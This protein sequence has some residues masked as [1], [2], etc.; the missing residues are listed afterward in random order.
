MN[1]I[2]IIIITSYL[3]GITS[4]INA[5]KSYKTYGSSSVV[6]TRAVSDNYAA[7]YHWRWAYWTDLWRAANSWKSQR[8]IKEDDWWSL[9]CIAHVLMYICICHLLVFVNPVL[10]LVLMLLFYSY[11][12]TWLAGWVAEWF[13]VLIFIKTTKMLEMCVAVE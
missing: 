8:N 10:L 6:V 12:F 13:G 1:F 9:S 4:V 3:L 5:T 7:S 11:S 2:F